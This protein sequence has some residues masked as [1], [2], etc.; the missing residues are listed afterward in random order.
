MVAFLGLG[1]NLDRDC[2]L[3]HPPT[4][5]LNQMCGKCGGVIHTQALNLVSLWGVFRSPLGRLY[6]IM[7]FR[8]FNSLKEL[9]KIFLDFS[10]MH[11][12]SGGIMYTSDK[13]VENI[14]K[15]ALQQGIPLKDLLQNCAL[16]INTLN[17]G[18]KSKKGIGALSLAKIADALECSMDYLTGR[19][20]C[21]D[22][23]QPKQ[24]PEAPASGEKPEGETIPEKE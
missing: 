7:I 18:A 1:I 5:F 15:R 12:L 3:N 4:P 11:N 24:A 10:N 14:R 17:Q 6:Y 2:N 23:A 20:D 9:F 22:V 16:N 8:D 19:T 13:L 21:P